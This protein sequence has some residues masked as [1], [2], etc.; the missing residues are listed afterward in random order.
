VL[1]GQVARHLVTRHGVRHVLL[2]GRRGGDAPGIAELVEEVAALGGSVQVAA[3]DVA[4]REALAALLAGIPA[5]HRLNGIVHAAGVLD[6]GMITSL[7]PDQVARVLRP[8]VDAAVNLHELTAG[9][10]LAMFVLFSSAAGVFGNPGQGNY[11][12]A[13]AFLDGLAAHRRAH[14]LPATSLAWGLWEQ[15]SGMTGHLGGAELARAAAGG[16][17]PLSTHQ[18]LALFDAALA[19][20][21]DDHVAPSFVPVALDISALRDRADT[22]AP[23]YRTLVRRPTRRTAQG[24][25]ASSI[26][27]GLA[28]RLADLSDAG[29]EELLV[30]LVRK[31]VAIVLGHGDRAHI[32][33]DRAFKDLGFDSLTAVELRNRLAEATGVRLPATLVFDNPTPT[34][35]ARRLRDELLAVSAAP[36]RAS[37]SARRAVGAGEPI[38]I[39][40]MACRYPGG[41]A[42]PEDLWQVVAEGRDVIGD[43]PADRGWDLDGVYDPDGERA[44]TTYTRSGGFLADAAGFDAGFF[45]IS[46]REALT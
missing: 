1:G 30:E 22:L 8:K 46:P 11:A 14:G 37:V 18:G 24:R 5:E 23:L 44:G 6:D 4:D 25:D 31:Y 35:L 2:V 12:A 28:A 38:A 27:S 10:D 16:V 34:A 20:G 43:F 45:G 17:R 32:D 21:A 13:N 26:A 36:A 40:G 29:R 15:A 7:S 19:A 33:V 3:C 41:V 39:V 9:S 42:S